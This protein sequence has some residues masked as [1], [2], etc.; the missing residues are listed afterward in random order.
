MD[1]PVVRRLK[2]ELTDLKYE[3]NSKLP[4][5]LETAREHGDLRENAEYEACKE[6]Q[7]FLN[8][9]IGQIEQRIRDMS[10]MSINSIPREAVGYGSIVIL[11]DSDDGSEC[12]Y[13]IVLPEEVD[14]AAGQISL[15][16]P[17]G[18]AL[19]NKEAGVEVEVRT[20]KGIRSYEIIKVET[21]HDREDMRE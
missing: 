10:L 5:E 6:R 15:G 21:I 13:E 3:L 14:A 4:K 2:K 18:R 12:R 20:P 16:S 7:G 9:R 17:L 8:A 1:L 19:Q 11:Q